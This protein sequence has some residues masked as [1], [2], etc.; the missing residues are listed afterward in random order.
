[1]AALF[2]PTGAYVSIPDAAANTQ[3]LSIFDAALVA[4]GLA[5]GLNDSAM[6]LTAFAPN[7]EA[8]DNFAAEQNITIGDLVDSAVI[9]PILQYHIVPFAV[10]ATDLHPGQSLPTLLEG[11]NITI[12]MP[13]AVAAQSLGIEDFDFVTLTG[14]DNDALIL[15]EDLQAGESYINIVDTVLKPSDQAIEEYFVQA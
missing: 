9:A 2:L 12:A 3:A 4:S 11:H 13:P 15:N 6:V 1:M 5:S 14:E 7:D 10:K 8:F